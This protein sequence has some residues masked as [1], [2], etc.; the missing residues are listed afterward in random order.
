[1]G[2][3]TVRVRV[4]LRAQRG[5]PWPAGLHRVALVPGALHARRPRRAREGCHRATESGLQTPAPSLSI[6]QRREDVVDAKQHVVRDE[7]RKQ[8]R[9]RAAPL[10]ARLLTH[11]GDDQLAKV[12]FVGCVESSYTEEASEVVGGVPGRVPETPVHGSRV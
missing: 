10:I 2:S 12:L 4:R 8:R 3:R 5:G 11:Q 9:A 7:G 1:M 6:V